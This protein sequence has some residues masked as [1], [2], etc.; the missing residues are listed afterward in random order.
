MKKVI[1]MA[2]M[3][4]LTLSFNAQN[5]STQKSKPIKTFYKSGDQEIKTTNQGNG[6]QIRFS[7]TDKR[8]GHGNAYEAAILKDKE[9]LI[10]FFRKVAEIHANTTDL[11]V[12]MDEYVGNEDKVSVVKLSSEPSVVYIYVRGASTAISDKELKRILSKIGA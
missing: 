11:T 1:L 7:F 9:A 10:T 3:F 4:L 2:L 6:D 5:R 12:D 8:E